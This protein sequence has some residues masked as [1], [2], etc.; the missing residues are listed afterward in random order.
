MEQTQV[1]VEGMTCEH[2]VRSVT[3][4]LTEIPNV[5]GVDVDLHPEAESAVTIRHDGPLDAALVQ[6][7]IGE[8][9]Y[10]LNHW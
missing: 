10:R 9:G 1:A 3:E 2:C 4:E 7:A 8:A 6:A 5:T